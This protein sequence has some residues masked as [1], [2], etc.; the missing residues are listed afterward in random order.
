MASAIETC[1]VSFAGLNRALRFVQKISR[2]ALQSPNH[3]TEAFASIGAVPEPQERFHA[4]KA[5]NQEALIE[6]LRVD[7]DLAFTFLETARIESG[8][9]PE[10]C[11]AALE[12]VRV[13]LESIRRFHSR[14]AN[15]VERD[16]I[17]VRSDKLEAALGAFKASDPGIQI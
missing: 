3:L 8:S 17:Q 6:F 10:H 7:L 14:I 11:K 9:D 5:K 1:G 16:R 13:A 12:K 2:R 4:L 15:S